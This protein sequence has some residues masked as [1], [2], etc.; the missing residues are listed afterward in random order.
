MLP[1]LNSPPKVARVGGE[2][3]PIRIEVDANGF[4]TCD[5]GCGGARTVLIAW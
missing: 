5:A 2:G 3:A 4:E 1:F